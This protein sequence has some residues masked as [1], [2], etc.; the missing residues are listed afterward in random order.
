[1]YRRVAASPA[2]WPCLVLL[3]EDRDTQQRA[4]LLRLRLPLPNIIIIKKKETRKRLPHHRLGVSEDATID[5][6][7]LDFFFKEKRAGRWGLRCDGFDEIFFDFF[8][9]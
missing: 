2:C 3:H 8:F 9:A 4:V 1:V 5:W 6:Y 7:A